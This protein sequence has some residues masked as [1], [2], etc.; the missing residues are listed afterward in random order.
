[1]KKILFLILASLTLSACGNKTVQNKITPTPAPKLVD[2]PLGDRPYVSL[3][4]REDGHMIYLKVTGIPS[5]VKQM[6]YEL[7]YTAVDSGNEIEKGVGDTVK[8]IKGSLEKSL[9]L[10]T[11]SCTNGCKYKYDEGIIGGTLSLTFISGDGQISTYETPFSLKTGAEIKKSGA[12][13]LS[14]EN[15][16]VKASPSDKLYYILLKNY[17]KNA[18]SI[19]SSSPSSSKYSSIEPSSVTKSDPLLTG[20]YINP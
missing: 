14:T 15:F 19:F 13:T 17:A 3:V 12:I 6:E 10:G 11:E 20:D 4:P 18:F 2:M 5:Y 9:L 8:D 16:S 7:L 1:M